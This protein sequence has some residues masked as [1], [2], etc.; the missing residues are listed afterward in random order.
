[1]DDAPDFLFEVNARA[2]AAVPLVLSAAGVGLLVGLTYAVPGLRPERWWSDPVALAVLGTV[3]CICAWFGGAIF[4]GGVYRVTLRDRRL[5]VDSP[6]RLVF[7]AGFEVALDQIERLTVRASDDWPEKY[8]VRMPAGTF[9]V[10]AVCG[11]GLFDAIRRL[12]PD[13]AYE[14]RV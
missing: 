5:R 14:R 4:R 3:L 13:I 12:R 9:R 6:S 8:E 1:M 10:D 2:Y 11:K 7:G